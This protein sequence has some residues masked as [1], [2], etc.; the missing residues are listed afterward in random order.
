MDEKSG[1][2]ISPD[3]VYAVDPATSKTNTALL[4]NPLRLNRYVYGLN[5][6]YRYVDPDGN[7]SQDIN[8]ND[9]NPYQLLDGGGV[10]GSGGGSYRGGSFAKGLWGK[11]TGKGSGAREG[12]EIV[13]RA[14][15]RAELEAIQGSG[16]LSR[17]GRA[18]DH[19]ASDAVNSNANRARQRLSL[20][21]SPEIRATLEVPSGVFSTP[22]KVAPKF[23]MPGGGMER[24]APGNKD[25]PAK[26]LD[27]LEY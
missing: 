14:M 13:Q 22:N 17:G 12:T 10:G 26:I 20:P 15:S 3:P 9:A 7:M 6:P 18:G 24:I 19:F 2:F 5:N 27:V 4:A 25:I 21:G 11:I 8:N 23:N 16:V 1:R